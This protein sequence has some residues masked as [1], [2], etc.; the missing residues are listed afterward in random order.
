DQSI[1]KGENLHLSIKVENKGVAPFYY[2]W[3]LVGYLVGADSSVA[4]QQDLGVD[5]RKWLPGESTVEA[6]IPL[7]DN[8]TSGSYDIK[9]SIND[10]QTGEPGVWFANTHR[11]S[12]GR[13]LVSRV[14]VE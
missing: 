3:P 13:Y 4:V 11:D 5:V 8:M 1:A 10:P 7:P 6:N 12:Q 14:S 2:E 9:L